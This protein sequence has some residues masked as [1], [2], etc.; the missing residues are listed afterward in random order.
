MANE[1]YDIA[2]PQL[3]RDA[4]RHDGDLV[5]LGRY[6]VNDRGDFALDDRLSGL[7][8]R[9]LRRLTTPRG[10]FYHLP[11]YGLA[12]EVKGP[13]RPSVLRDLAADARSQVESEPGVVRASVAVQQL[14]AAPNILVI[15]ALVQ[16]TGGLELSVSQRILVGSTGVARV[17]GAE[18]TPPPDVLIDDLTG[19]TLVDDLTGDVLTDG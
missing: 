6:Q 16:A 7:R 11:E 15:T 8:K 18:P 5:P 12:Q 17:A 4:P 9:V 10:G 14:R 2:N 19:D 13:I 1:P 3:L